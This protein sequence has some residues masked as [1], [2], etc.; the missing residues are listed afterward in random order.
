LPPP[1]SQQTH[2]GSLVASRDGTRL[3][4]ANPDADSVSILD[5]ARHTILHEVL[6]APAAP[7]L[8]AAGRYDPPS[9]P[10]RSR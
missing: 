2:S 9:S 10:A 4:V 5:V 1:G 8:T 7:A 3:F 6:L